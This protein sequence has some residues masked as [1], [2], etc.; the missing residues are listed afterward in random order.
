MYARMGRVCAH[1]SGVGAAGATSAFIRRRVACSTALLLALALLPDFFIA[2]AEGVALNWPIRDV[3]GVA[4]LQVWAHRHT[5]PAAAEA[6]LLQAGSFTTPPHNASSKWRKFKVYAGRLPPNPFEKVASA[7]A[8]ASSPAQSLPSAS[9]PLPSASQRVQTFGTARSVAWQPGQVEEMEIDHPLHLGLLSVLACIYFTL[10]A[11]GIRYA[12]LLLSHSTDEAYGSARMKERTASG[13]GAPAPGSAAVHAAQ[14]PTDAVQIISGRERSLSSGRERSLSS[15]GGSSPAMGV[16]APVRFQAPEERPLWSNLEI[17]GLTSYR[18]YTGFLSATWLPYLLAMEGVDLYGDQQSVLMGEAKLI[19]GV[20]ILMNPVFGIIGDHVARKS[21]GAGRRLFL[22]LGMSIAALGMFV[23]LLSD[24]DH[25]RQKFLL[26]I[27]LWRIGDCSCDVTTEALVPELVPQKQ[28]Q[29][30]S[31]IKASGFL[32]GGVLGYAMLLGFTDWHYTWLYYAYLI[33]MVTCAI[34]SLMLLSKDH[35]PGLKPKRQAPEGLVA[36]ITQAYLVPLSFAGG[37]PL[38]CLAVMVFGLGTCP[39]FFMLLM[40]RD[41]VGIRVPGE[42]QRHFS[43]ASIVFFS[44]AAISSVLGGLASKGGQAEETS[45]DSPPHHA[46]ATGEVVS[47][48]PP[49]DPKRDLSHRIWILMCWVIVFAV[50]E[51]LMPCIVLLQDMWSRTVA[52]YALSALSGACFG[53]SFTRFQDCTWD[54]LPAG[55]NVAN[56]M[57]FNVMCRLFGVGLGNFIAGII[58]DQFPDT[59][60]YPGG[61]HEGYMPMGYVILCTGSGLL[62]LVSG[63]LITG[64]IQKTQQS[65]KPIGNLPGSGPVVPA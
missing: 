43:A 53:A 5:P 48:P 62:I 39:I 31:S 16:K 50:S 8:S 65:Q 12:V 38:A 32:V 30:A 15:G 21:H 51:L 28:F 29:L 9:S 35:P 24:T 23:C 45:T 56:A 63:A 47:L 34:P 14:S 10:F 6:K 4:A 52:F 37:F 3:R 22:C 41:V 27:L 59:N 11:M 44:C 58:L 1:S 17:V 18:F 61:S 49:R 7:A 60:L 57:G 20:T 64:V 40:V 13:L 46:G 42:Q 55:A 19:Y 25:G 2:P 54:I 26:G 36:A 33:G